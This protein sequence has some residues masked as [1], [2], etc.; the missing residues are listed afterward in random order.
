MEIVFIFLIIVM[1]KG[2][3]GGEA[4]S[5]GGQSGSGCDFVMSALNVQGSPWEVRDRDE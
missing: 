1:K 4:N 3:V 5:L 2:G